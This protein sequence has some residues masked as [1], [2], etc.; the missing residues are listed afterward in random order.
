MATDN[1]RPLREELP[2]QTEELYD[3]NW[4]RQ[5]QM[6]LRIKKAMDQGN[7]RMANVLNQVRIVE[8]DTPV[9][10]SALSP[11]D[12][13][14]PGA[15]RAAAGK[16]SGLLG[17]AA[18]MA[19]TTAGRGGAPAAEGMV[20]KRALGAA[21]DTLP[22]LGPAPSAAEME[23]SNA[24]FMLAQEAKWKAGQQAHLD[25]LRAMAKSTPARRG[26][27]AKA[28]DADDLLPLPPRREEALTPGWSPKPQ[29]SATTWNGMMDGVAPT[30]WAAL[31][32]KDMKT[33][34]AAQD[35]AWEMGIDPRTNPEWREALK[36]ALSKTGEA[37]PEQF[38][39]PR[40]RAFLGGKANPE[41]QSMP[42]PLPPRG[43]R[44]P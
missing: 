43:K 18:Q 14:G 30:Q 6:R 35:K 1:P 13:F 44:A 21:D 29:G 11:V 17:R 19:A 8:E 32:A 10:P 2:N 24:E 27:K 39:A 12:M 38:R 20:L 9:E 25:E 34:G 3:P 23:A 16:A 5:A 40:L 28:D 31:H 37:Y 26:A 36:R 7:P 4:V 33:Y 22:P 15:V 41:A 42:T